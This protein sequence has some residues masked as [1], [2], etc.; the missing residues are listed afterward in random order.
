V[1]V[2]KTKLSAI[3]GISVSSSGFFPQGASGVAFA[4]YN[5]DLSLL[6]LFPLFPHFL[7][8]EGLSCNAHKRSDPTEC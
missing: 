3:P 5:F 1:N 4:F 2:G 8:V 6:F 7:C